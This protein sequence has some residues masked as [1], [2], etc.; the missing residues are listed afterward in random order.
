[1]PLNLYLNQ[2]ICDLDPDKWD[3]AIGILRRT[4]NS[5]P[6]VSKRLKLDKE[7]IKVI[8]RRSEYDEMGDKIKEEWETVFRI[9][10]NNNS[11]SPYYE[12][13]SLICRKYE[14]ETTQFTV[15]MVCMVMKALFFEQFKL[16]TESEITDWLQVAKSIKKYSG[17]DF[18]DII[19]KELL[20]NDKAF[21]KRHAKRITTQPFKEPV[22][23]DDVF[24]FSMD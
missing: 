4:A 21:S 17:L 5:L 8:E 3:M 6:A 14:D 20:K 24:P 16:E 12:N 2:E 19:A 22:N 15:Q 11:N 23:Y 7:W 9:V 1:M 10:K 18:K 13:R